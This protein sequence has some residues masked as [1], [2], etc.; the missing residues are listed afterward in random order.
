M[1]PI[2]AHMKQCALCLVTTELS[3]SHIIPNSVFRRI[4]QENQGKA[5]TF[6][7][8]KQSP[9]KYSSDSWWEYLLCCDCE[10]LL[11][12]HYEGYSIALL[13]GSQGRVTR[14]NHGVTIR[15]ANLQRFQLFLMS[16]YWRAAVSSHPSYS[17]IFITEPFGSEIRKAL[18][19]DCPIA[20]RL[21]TIKI[22]RLIDYTEGGFSL[23][24]LKSLIISPFARRVTSGFS[25][26]F[27]IEGFFIEIFTPGL[28]HKS[29]SQKG[30]LHPDKPVFLIPY[31]HIFD[32]PEIFNLMMSGYGKHINNNSNI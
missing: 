32:V 8:D 21:A 5:I 24:V 15:E 22:S 14:G 18:K 29:R 2:S 7:D 1:S 9:I 28:R 3:K 17:T 6:S 26:C 13:R 16:V 27:L 20:L 10:S 11:N 4:L 31:L 25:F 12:A 23:S 19:N 30:I